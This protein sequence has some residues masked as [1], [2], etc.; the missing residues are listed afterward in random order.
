MQGANITTGL[1]RL[2]L[3]S[4]ATQ[5]HITPRSKAAAHISELGVLATR[6]VST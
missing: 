3:S 1:I 2:V 6:T 4:D 5:G